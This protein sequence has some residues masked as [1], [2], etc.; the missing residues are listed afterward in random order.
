MGSRWIG[1]P[2]RYEAIGKPLMGWESP[3]RFFEDKIMSV[4]TT[5]KTVREAKADGLSALTR[6]LP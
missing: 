3:E 6:K 2:I 5:M 4:C 1:L